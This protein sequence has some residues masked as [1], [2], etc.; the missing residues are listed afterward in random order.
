MLGPVQ[1]EPRQCKGLGGAALSGRRIVLGEIRLSKGQPL[2]GEVKSSEISMTDRYMSLSLQAQSALGIVKEIA[3]GTCSFKDFREYFSIVSS[4]KRQVKRLS[5]MRTA[6]WRLIAR[7]R[8]AKS[9]TSEKEN[10]HAAAYDRR[11]TIA[12]RRIRRIRR[13][14]R[15]LGRGGDVYTLLT[16]R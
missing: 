3:G 5:Q 4:S 13:S 9:W 16:L 2:T 12:R 14:R 10:S 8:A 7:P 15:R 1:G 6:R 11:R